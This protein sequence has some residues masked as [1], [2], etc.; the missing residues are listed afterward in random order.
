MLANVGVAVEVQSLREAYVASAGGSY[1][2]LTVTELGLARE[3]FVELLDDPAITNERQE[4][5]ARLGFR[6]R[7]FNDVL[8]L[9]EEPDARRGGGFFAFATARPLRHVLQAPHRFDDTHTGRMTLDL[10][11]SGHFRAAAWSTLHRT[12]VDLAH[13]PSSVFIAFAEA[14]AASHP[15]ELQYQ[16]HGFAAH[17]CKTSACRAASAILSP[18]PL[19]WNQEAEGKV[20]CLSQSLPKFR[21][22]REDVHELGGTRNS[23]A[24]ALQALNFQGFIH[25]EMERALRDQL[26]K[27]EDK[28]ADALRNQLLRCLA[29]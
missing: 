11:G 27:R 13:T 8:V 25:I 6:L 9:S 21:R 28:N 18:G 17:K 10:F 4:Y 24:N 14:A 1:Q 3:G 19:N 5:W 20:A 15:Q 16:I 26:I 12:D 22:Y 7:M 2:P 29:G 23:V